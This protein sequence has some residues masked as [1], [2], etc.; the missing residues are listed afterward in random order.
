MLGLASVRADRIDYD[1][2]ARAY[3]RS[4][5]LPSQALEG[6]R[7]ALAPYLAATAGRVLDLGSGTGHFAAALAQWFSVDVVGVEPSPG[8]I[9]EARSEN[10]HPLV[11]YV[12]GCGEWLPLSD[13]SCSAAWLSTVVHQVEDLPACA[14]ELAR[15]LLP[16]MPVLIRGAF[17]GRLDHI[18]LFRFFPAAR[19]VAET[20][21]SID[22]LRSVFT[23]AGITLEAVED[24]VQVSA[25]N[26]LAAVKGL[27]AL[28]QADS[29][30]AALDDREFAAGLRAAE[31]VAE[32]DPDSPVVDRLTLVV[33]RR[34]GEG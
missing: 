24:V 30:L 5:G 27:P 32:A 25:P 20:F 14:R 21:P 17:P 22:D 4:R 33:L 2:E 3:S 1:G 11:T 13:A 23:R 16:G 6:W 29:T 19:R 7:R 18:T 8:M 26:L 12:R 10:A 15:V 34:I 31:R 28:R 9:A